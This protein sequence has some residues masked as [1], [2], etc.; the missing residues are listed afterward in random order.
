M[1]KFSVGILH[2]KNFYISLI[3]IIA[4]FANYWVYRLFQT[5]IFLGLILILE[6]YLLFLSVI[7]KNRIFTFLSL[8]TLILLSII[9]MK[10]YFNQTVLIPSKIETIQQLKNHEYYANELGKAYKNKYGLIYFMEIKPLVNR[11][12]Y[13][14]FSFLDLKKYFEFDNNLSLFYPIF[15]FP[16]FTIGLIYSVI[17]LNTNLAVYFVLSLLVNPF[18]NLDDNLNP[19]LILPLFNIYIA[20]GVIQA[21]KF[22]KKLS[23]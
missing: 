12:T 9:L 4:C 2:S 15:L 7:S 22:L 23:F 14:I 10:N 11:I 6:S 16:F 13:Q 1:L 19:I 18:I 3:V 8:I 5:N 20:L 17:N 21:S